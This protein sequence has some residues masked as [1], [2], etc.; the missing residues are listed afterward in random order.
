MMIVSRSDLSEKSYNDVD[1]D[2]D[3]VDDD[4]EDNDDREQVWS[5]REELQRGG[6]SDRGY[7]HSPQVDY[8]VII[9]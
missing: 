2:D 5:L 6:W 8:N 1:D 3:N 7:L 4:D 9:D